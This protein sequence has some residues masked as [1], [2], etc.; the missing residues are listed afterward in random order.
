LK[1]NEG[2]NDSASQELNVIRNAKEEAE[3]EVASLKVQIVNLETK[4]EAR[5]Q[6]YGRS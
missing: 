1:H 4:Y 3:K 5:E 2:Q 6:E